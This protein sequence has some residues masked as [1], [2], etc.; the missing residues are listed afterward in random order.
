MFNAMLT[1]YNKNRD[2]YSLKTLDRGIMAGSICPEELMKKCN[3]DLGIK[4]LSICYGMT[5][6]SPVS[7]QTLPDDTFEQQTQTV[8]KVHPHIE[9]KICDENG[10]TL[11]R[12]EKGEICTRGYSTML[13]Y[14]NDPERTRETIDK[15]GWAHTG[16]LGILDDDGYLEIVGR[17]KDMIIRGGENIFPKEIE[18]YLLAHPDISDAQVIGV[19]DEKFGEEIMA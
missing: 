9:C 13:Y 4:Y 5:E 15:N 19:K 3:S 10:K 16:D 12:G 1:H 6:T 8:G 7:F 11:R 18:N 14:W 17:V 2:N